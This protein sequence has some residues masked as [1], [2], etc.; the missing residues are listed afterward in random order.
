MSAFIMDK[1]A[2]YVETFGMS[3]DELLA[4]LVNYH[5]SYSFNSYLNVDYLNFDFDSEEYLARLVSFFRTNGV[6]KD[7]AKRILISTPLILSCK[8]PESDLSLIYK[9]DSI[10]GIVVYDER[11]DYHLYRKKSNALRS[12]IPTNSF[13]EDL[14]VD[15]NNRLILSNTRYRKKY[16]VKNDCK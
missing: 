10:E 2:K 3:K 16:Y 5:D 6:S 7:Q 8:N 4:F 12:I 11:G 1:Y 13:M 14:S 9:D 15:E